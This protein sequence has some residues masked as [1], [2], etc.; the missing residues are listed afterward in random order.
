MSKDERPGEELWYEWDGS[1]YRK[2]SSK[3]LIYYTFDHV[4]VENE[5]VRRALASAIQRDGVACSLGD[6]FKL[7]E[8]S[9]INLGWVGL[10]EEEFE[11][12]VCNENSET[13][14][15]DIVENIQSV[16]WIEI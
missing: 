8:T 11:F 13:E 5:V 9:I 12:M 14:Y 16:T 10:L 7:I 4:D 1:G 2:V 6:G 15:G 3:E